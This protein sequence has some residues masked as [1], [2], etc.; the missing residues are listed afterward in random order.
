ME[1]V[2]CYGIAIPGRQPGEGPN[3]ASITLLKVRATD[4]RVPLL[5][6]DLHRLADELSIRSGA[7]TRRQRRRLSAVSRA[8][9]RRRRSRSARRSGRVPA[10]RYRR[11]RGPLRGRRRHALVGRRE[12]GRPASPSRT[13]AGPGRRPRARRGRVRRGRPTV[14]D[15]QSASVTSPETLATTFGEPGEPTDGMRPGGQTRR[16]R[17]DRRLGEVVER[18]TG[19]RGRADA[20]SSGRRQL[21]GPDEEVVGE[22]GARRRRRCPRRTS[23]RRS[24]SGSGSSWTWWRIP[25]SRS[26][27]GASRS[28]RSR[29]RPP[30]RSG[31]PSRRRRR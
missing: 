27:P 30:D 12:R 16:R 9:G 31:R 5:V 23:A 6:D 11:R 3:A 19:H 22:A 21:A 1:G 20:V 28:R 13:A 26:P 14:H 2:V 17:G 7:S 25:T 8:A 18:R 15:D 24:Q 4:E 10:C 29:R